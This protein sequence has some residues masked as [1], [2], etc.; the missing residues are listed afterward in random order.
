MLGL[1]RPL[2]IVGLALLGLG[3]AASMPSTQIARDCSLDGAYALGQAD[4]TAGRPKVERQ[5]LVCPD[6]VMRGRLMNA[7][8]QGYDEA[9]GS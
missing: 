7:Y 2:A 1:M 3:C 6:S 4:A 8:R 9:G 5:L